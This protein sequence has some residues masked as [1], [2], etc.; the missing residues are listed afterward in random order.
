MSNI[1]QTLSFPFFRV[2]FIIHILKV[3]KIRVLSKSMTKNISVQTEIDAS[4]IYKQVALSSKD[5]ATA[6]IFDQMSFIEMSHALAMQKNLKAK[7]MDFELP[8]P[9]MR[10][11]VLNKLWKVFGYSQVVWQML[12]TEKK[13]ARDQKLAKIKFNIPISGTE[14]NHV[15]I[16][17]NVLSRNEGLTGENISGLEGKH[18]SIGGNALRAAV[19]WANDGLVS[20]MSLVMGVAGATSGQ[21]VLIAGM[22]GLLAWALSMSLGEWISVRS[23]QEL[24]EQQMDV[25]MEE[26]TINPEGEKRELALIY[27]SKGIPEEEAHKLANDVMKDINFAHEVFVKEELG[28]NTEDLK[29]SAWEAAFASFFLFVV[30]A[31]LPVFPFFFIKWYYAIIASM[32]LSTIW[33]FII[34]S[35]ITLFTGKPMLY[36]GVRQ[37]IFWLAAAGITYSIGVVLWVSLSY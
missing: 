14:D 15:K 24:Y 19:L 32:W 17:E 30:W 31:I 2:F 23:S 8:P 5:A 37:V 33:L 35:A 26:L 12:D 9:S 34:G 25:E 10:I 16:L 11:K 13:L 20:N 4:Y 21:W 28:I 7:G 6:S 29:S 18:K 22:A 1:F 3:P 36:S 27:M